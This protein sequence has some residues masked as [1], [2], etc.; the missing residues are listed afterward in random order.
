MKTKTL[1]NNVDMKTKTSQNN[2]RI[3]KNTTTQCRKK[4][5]HHKTM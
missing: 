5:K 1:Q 2:V 3:M 4:E